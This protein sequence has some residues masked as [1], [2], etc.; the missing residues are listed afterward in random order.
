ME[1]SRD[2]RGEVKSIRY[3]PS[4]S[5]LIEVTVKWEDR[6]AI[7]I[8]HKKVEE[9]DY[10]LRNNDCYIDESKDIT[11]QYNTILY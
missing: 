5:S 6:K 9:V 4:L 11:I 10:P 1:L 7:D 8:L 3:K 2:T